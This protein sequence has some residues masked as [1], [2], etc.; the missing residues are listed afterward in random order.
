M[1]DHLGVRALVGRVVGE[2]GRQR[3]SQPAERFVGLRHEIDDVGPPTDRAEHERKRGLQLDDLLD[4]AA[5]VVLEVEGRH[6]RVDERHVGRDAVRRRR[7][8]PLTQALH[9]NGHVDRDDDRAFADR[10]A[11][12]GLAQF[13]GTGLGVHG[14]KRIRCTTDESGQP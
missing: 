6:E 3:V 8:H 10:L 7:V 9:G 13:H 4:A 2:C 5:D 14:A 1:R 12:A 11:P